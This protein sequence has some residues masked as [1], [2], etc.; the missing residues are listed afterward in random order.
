[1]ASIDER[2]FGPLETEDVFKAVEQL[3]LDE[4]PLPAKALAKRGLRG[5]PE[6]EPD[7]RVAGKAGPNA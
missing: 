2:Y 5:G 1:M 4:D 7:D 3:L 6:G